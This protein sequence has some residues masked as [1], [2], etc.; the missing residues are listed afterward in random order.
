MTFLFTQL[1]SPFRIKW[2][3]GCKCGLNV[4][5]IKCVCYLSMILTHR[6]STASSLVKWTLWCFMYFSPLNLIAHIYW[7]PF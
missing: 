6:F 7:K 4:Q 3:C 1:L 5:V 2:Y